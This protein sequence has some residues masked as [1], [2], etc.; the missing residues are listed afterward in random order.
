MTPPDSAATW[1]GARRLLKSIRDVMAGGGSGQQRL[2]DIVCLIAAEV[3]AEV[4]S[5][6]VRRA[7]DV[8]ELF[9]TEGL[10]RGAVHRTR[11]GIGEGLVGDIAQHARPLALADA[12][13]HPNFAYRPETGEEVYASLMGVPVLRGGRVLGVLVVQNRTHRHYEEEEIE[14]LE[15]IA[16]VLAEVIAGG[17]LL[18]PDEAAGAEDLVLPPQR[19]EGLT[20]HAGLARGH[21]VLHQPRITIARMVADDPAAEQARIA[22][23]VDAMQGSLEEMLERPDLQA[24]GEHRDILETY[25]MFARDRGWLKRIDEAVKSGLTAEA[26]VQKVQDDT[27]AR[28]SQVADAYLRERLHDLED[29]ANRLLHHLTGNAPPTVAELPYD[30]VLFARNLGPA[31]LLNY[32]STRLRGIVLEEGSATAHAAIVARALD[33]PMVGKTHDVLS[34]VEEGDTVLLDA[35]NGQVFVRPGADVQ[36][37]F[38]ASMA[39]REER[40]AGLARLRELPAETRDGAQLQMLINAGLLID[41]PQLHRT[42]AEGIG[43]YRTEIPFMVRDAYPDVDDQADLYRRILDQADGKPVVFR[44]LDVG[45][46]KLLP[47]FGDRDEENPAMGWRAVRIALDRPAMLRQQLRALITAAEGRAL[48]VMFPMI[49]E[50]EEFR[51]ARRVLDLELQRAAARGKPV[52]ATVRCGAMLEVPAL[53]WQ[54]GELARHADFVSVGSNDLMQFLFASDRGNP[55]LEGRYDTLSPAALR[56]LG[57]IARAC[58]AAQ[59]PVALCGEM[60]GRP[61][62]ALALVGLGYRTLSM[63]P[64][65]VGPVKAM[66]R[67]VDTG[68]LAAYLDEL[69]R[70]PARSVRGRLRAFAKDHNIAV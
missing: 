60:A 21:A 69:M 39:A 63:A 38:E 53:T 20:L 59:V 50:V 17:H 44:T 27:R 29:L 40:L 66:V 37:S 2:D 41:V 56:V 49:A 25:A 36:A 8:L 64:A 13:S 18:G 54:L 10:R 55:R 61:L 35:D 70:S 51:G 43:L 14:A 1:S 23:A 7:G 22:A 62:E 42:G 28:M 16:M 31:E 11:L 32:D 6:Y 3:V 9:A 47:Y 26:A 30:T 34:L 5:V 33:V 57:E 65:S 19:A 58:Q 4:C 52:P 46:D 48:S 45:G 68:P 12:Q 15:T 67:S 24:G